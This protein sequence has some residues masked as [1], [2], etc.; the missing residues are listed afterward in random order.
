MTD[1]VL[2]LPP[3]PSLGQLRIQAKE[4]L[5][6]LRE[7]APDTQLADAQFALAR[8]YGF[9]TWA[10]LV[11]HV[12]ALD[13]RAQSPRIVSPVSRVIGTRDMARARAFW[14]DMLGFEATPT[15]DNADA[16]E[17]RSGEARIRLGAHD[18]APDFSGD[19]HAPGT[20]MLHFEVDDVD[21]MRATLLARGAP[22]SAIEKV[23]WLK[24]RMFEVRDPDGHVL[25][26]GQTY[27][28]DM[29]A[30]PVEQFEKVLPELPVDDVATA[31]RHYRDV[32]GFGIN[33]AQDDIAVMDRDAITVLLIARTPAHRGIGSLYAYVRDVDALHAE[34]VATGA[35]VQGEPVS[36]PWGLR[37]F[38]VHDPFG[39]R[40][41]LGQP[42]E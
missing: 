24:F 3:R 21:A 7:T 29:P 18:W 11:H 40:L 22:A 10:A 4:R 5:T 14:C 28:V 16:L 8:G 12:A 37:E 33:Y 23:N 13:P 31:L 1:P 25:W 26:F 17:L 35:D 39:N 6:A 42:F 20:A 34:L 2:R 32:L 19:G 36:Q 30:R 27:N 9:T 38:A 15:T 41:R